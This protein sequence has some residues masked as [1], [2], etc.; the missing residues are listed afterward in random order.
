M[1]LTTEAARWFATRRGIAAETLDAFGAT[2]DGAE[3]VVFPYS[4]RGQQARKYR[5]GFEKED[6]R[7][8]WWDP[9]A[10]AGQLPFLPPDFEDGNGLLLVEGETDTMALW[11]HAPADV[12]RR[13]V[14]LSGTNAYKDHYAEQLFADSKYVFV[15]FDRDDP[16][17]AADAVKATESAYNK[18]KQSLGRKARRIVL[19][20]GINDIAEFFQTYDWAA[21]RS[22]MDAAAEVR[23]HFPAL[24]LTA[25]APPFDWIIGDLVVRGDIV[26]VTAEPGTGKSFLLQDLA[27]RTVEKAPT[28]LGLP[29]LLKQGR[30]MYVDQ[31]NPMA[32]VRHRMSALGLT[33]ELSENLR[34]LWYPNLTLDRDA[35]ALYEDVEAFEP[36]FIVFDS[37]SRVHNKNENKAEEINPLLN[38]S[39]Y[40]LSRRLGATIFLV[41]HMNKE[42]GIRGSTAWGAAADLSL[43]MVNEETKKG[44]ATG[45][46]LLVPDKLRNVPKWGH[47]LKIQRKGN[48]SDGEQVRHVNVYDEEEL[49]F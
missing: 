42:G 26:L 48:A 38:E 12:K 30:V 29:L 41:H 33:A 35:V 43:L 10:L 25:E 14:G 27:V 11:Q 20:Q 31:E 47:T 36:D 44:A 3:T 17:T 32:T 18:V 28:W 39:V 15:V 6:G 8:F 24:D 22:L 40:P 34:Y 4:Y 21:F 46:Q 13:I 7:R 1:G 9:P 5:K 19:P 45:R 49:D 23:Y 2:S 16:Y 37:V